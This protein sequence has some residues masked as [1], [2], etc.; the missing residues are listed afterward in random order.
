MIIQTSPAPLW[1]DIIDACL[2]AAKSARKT[3]WDYRLRG[4]MGGYRRAIRRAAGWRQDARQY[5]RNEL[6][7]EQ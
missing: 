6:E 5:R 2:G 1:D 3:A 4:D 7:I